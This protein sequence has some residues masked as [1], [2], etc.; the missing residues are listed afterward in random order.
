VAPS[1]I[2]HYEVYSASADTSTLTTPSFTPTNGEVLVVKLATWD[3]ANG[4]AAPSGGSQTY[5]SVNVVAPGGF[6]GWCAVYV[7]TVSGS[8]GSM[9]VSAAPATA[10]STR[11]SMVVE[12]WSGAQL[13]ATPATNSTVAG[14]STLPSASITTVGAN[15]V[16]SWVSVDV[17]SVDPATRAYLL[18]A[19]EDGLYD[20]H[21]G[22]N[23]VHYFAYAAVGAAGS[24]TIGMSAPA[25]QKWVMAGVEVQAAAVASGSQPVP[26]V[27]DQPAAPGRGRAVILAPQGG[28]VAAVPAPPALVVGKQLLLAPRVVIVAP[29]PDPGTGP[30]ASSGPPAVV[31]ALSW[32]PPAVRSTILAPNPDPGPFAPQPVVVA[33]SIRQAVRTVVLAPLPGLPPV[34]STGPAAVVVTAAIRPRAHAFI[35]RP[36]ADPGAVQAL[37]PGAMTAASSAPRLASATASARLTATTS[38]GDA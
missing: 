20:G 8:P 25:S 38:G 31:A 37:V 19:T 23:S 16:L 12:R 4:M 2:T 6:A 34:P 30:A 13:A 28:Q 15:S 26:V 21:A 7:A 33:A 9:T 22:A 1:L 17:Q 3:T 5:Q 10:T 11:H 27:V 18:S 14:T 29:N 24:Y 36:N 35:A 32:R